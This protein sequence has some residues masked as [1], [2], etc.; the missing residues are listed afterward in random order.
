MYSYHLWIILRESTSE[1]DTGSFAGKLD[2]LRALV[3]AKLSAVSAT[4]VQALNVEHILQCS[5]SH[6]H[7]GDVHDRL[8]LVLKWIIKEFPGSYGLVY[9]YDDERP[10]RASFD[11]Y[12]VIVIARGAL[13]HRYDP[14]ISPIAPTVEE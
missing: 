6:N 8:L 2:E 4:P 14:F 7:R 1:A 12:N 13:L 9:W 11:G 10:G 5:E 3:G